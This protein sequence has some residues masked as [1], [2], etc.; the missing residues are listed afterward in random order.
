M[1][2]SMTSCQRSVFSL[3]RPHIVLLFALTFFFLDCFTGPKSKDPNA[4]WFEMT[5]VGFIEGELKCRIQKF[6]VEYLIAA[7]LA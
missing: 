4:E 2:P 5:I 7:V 3:N 1:K 6:Y